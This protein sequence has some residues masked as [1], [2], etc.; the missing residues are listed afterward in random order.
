[1]DTF[2]FYLELGFS[3]ILDIGAYD[4][5]LFLLALCAL[6]TPVQWKKV[7]ILIT[8]FTIGH[9]LTLAMAAFNWLVIPQDTTEFLIAL[10]ILLTALY[11]IFLAKNAESMSNNKVYFSYL[12]A[13]LFGLIHGMGFSYLLNQLKSSDENIFTVLLSFNVG[14][15]IGQ[16]LY[17]IVIMAIG[18]ILILLARLPFVY[19]KN[20]LSVIAGIIALNMMYER[21]EAFFNQLF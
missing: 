12:M 19:W 13:L 9:S 7:L 18:T 17:V 10:T 4:H 16:I 2:L 11:N 14:I 15:E 20:G 3:H 1:M 21:A 5:M 6:Y 8:A